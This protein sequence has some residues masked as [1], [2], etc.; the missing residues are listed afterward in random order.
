MKKY[1]SRRSGLFTLSTSLLC[2]LILNVGCSSDPESEDATGGAP[3]TGGT[4]ASGGSSSGGDGSGG[5]ASGGS[6]SGGSSSGGSSTGGNG[7]G[8]SMGGMGGQSETGGTNPGTG[9]DSMGG[10]GGETGETAPVSPFTFDEDT[11]GFKT[12]G[13]SA[14]AGSTIIWDASCGGDASAKGCLKVDVPFDAGGG[15]TLFVRGDLDE[16]TD[17]T[18]YKIVARV[19]VGAS[20]TG[21]LKSYIQNTSA[22]Y[23]V[24]SGP[25]PSVPLADAADWKNIELDTSNANGGDAG[26]A[27]SSEV[28]R[29]GLM[30]LSGSTAAPLATTVYVDSIEVL[31]L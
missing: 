2:G 12:H 17:L 23:K 4:S 22:G 18:G 5:N 3:A 30:V 27:L 8:G 21:G 7:T 25:N 13:G 24:A 16:I 29:L 11:E 28:A 31:P 19:R 6:S 26:E 9:G 10:A 1:F 15:E 14:P 20:G